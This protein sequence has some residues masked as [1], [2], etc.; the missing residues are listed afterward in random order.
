VDDSSSKGR[1]DEAPARTSPDQRTGRPSRKEAEAAVRVLLRWAGE[2]PDRE[3][4]ADTPK[5]VVKSYEEFFA[6]YDK[7]PEEILARTF[8]ETNGYDEMVVLRDI[9]FE[10]HCE[11]HI[12]PIIGTVHIAYIPDHRVVGISKLARLVEIVSKRLQIQERMTAMI[13]QCL[14]N[15]LQPKGVAVVVEGAHQCMTTRGIHKPGTTMLT[16]HMTG[17]F[18]DDDKTRR[19]FLAMIGDPGRRGLSNT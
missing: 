2:D 11:H 8:T 5:R 13:A 12:A 14:E 19:E 16:S 6:G 17:A 10:S 15:V 4:L 18:R 3:G 1:D 9:R 7:D